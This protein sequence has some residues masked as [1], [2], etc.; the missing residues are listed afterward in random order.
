MTTRKGTLL[1]FCEGRKDTRSD[2]GNIDIVLRR[3]NDKGQT[4]S[5]MV[6]LADHGPDTIGNPA[7]VQD[8]KTGT[9][10]LLLAGNPGHT[11]ERE[12]IETGEKGTRTV[13]VMSSSDD[14]V[15]WSKPVEITKDVKPDN[16]T[17]YATGPVNGIQTR[18]GRLVIPCDHEVKGHRGFYSHVIYSDD[19]GK[20][21]KLGGSASELT[22]ESTVAELSDGA[23]MLNMRSNAKRYRRSVSLSKDGGVTWSAPVFDETLIEPTCQ[24][25]LVRFSRKR[26]DKR[27]LF[28]N[29][30]AEKRAKMTVRLSDDDG[31]TWKHS[32]L[33]HQG[34]SAY[35]S[36]A[37]LKDGTIG[38]LYEKGA[39]Q[40]YET[41]AFARFDLD[42][43]RQ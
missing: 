4:W 7:P 30:A 28:S 18:S 19:H 33:V 27:L 17:W 22:D 43:I 25:S 13:W 41:I 8:E 12:I 40:A 10:W 38:L 9:I 14:G 21:W 15:T 34:P 32:K 1:A 5:P 29:P 26:G 35:S 20:S 11:S 6:T 36:L 2:T 42:W 24:G 3:S 39:Q 31:K 37:V 23:L 16:W